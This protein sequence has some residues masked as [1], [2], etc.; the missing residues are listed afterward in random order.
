MSALVASVTQRVDHDCRT[1]HCNKGKCSI[2]LKDAPAQRVIVDLDCAT[3]RMP[4][5]R[6][7]CDYLFVGEVDDTAWVVPIEL[8]GGGFKADEVVEQLQGGSHVADE[9]LPPKSSFEF[10]PVLAHGKR[11]HRKNFSDLRHRNITLRRK[12]SRIVTLRCGD[13]LVRALRKSGGG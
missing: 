8:K 6:K 2:S 9:Q 10:V 7:R 1:N 13:K 4:A 5:I 3:L 11:V 12:K